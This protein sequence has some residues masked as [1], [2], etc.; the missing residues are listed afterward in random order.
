MEIEKELRSFEADHTPD[1]WPAVRMR[2]VSALC[3]EVD[4]LKAIEAAARNLVKVKGRYH[5]EQAFKALAALLVNA[6]AEPA[7][8][9]CN[10]TPVFKHDRRTGEWAGHC[11]HCA[12]EGRAATTETEARRLWI[13]WHHKRSDATP[14]LVNTKADR[15]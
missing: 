11:E 5:T 10:Q 15:P 3:D 2:Q 4:R 7:C 12:V 9:V 1:G 14:V 13:A 8:P 6:P